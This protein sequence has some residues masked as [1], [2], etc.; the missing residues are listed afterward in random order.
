MDSKNVD[1]SSELELENNI[2]DALE[3]GAN[4]N[5]KSIDGEEDID[6]EFTSDETR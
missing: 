2:K 6:E 4:D 5:Q 3:E 1:N